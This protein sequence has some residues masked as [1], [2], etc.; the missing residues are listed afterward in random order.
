MNG[1]KINVFILSQDIEMGMINWM[2]TDIRLALDMKNMGQV[3]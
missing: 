3:S 2:I 1:L